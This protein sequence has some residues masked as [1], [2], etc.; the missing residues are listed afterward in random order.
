M[1]VDLEALYKRVK[2]LDELKTDFFANV[3][4]E[5]RTPL[6]LILGPIDRL[7]LH[8]SDIPRGMKADLELARRSARVLQKQVNDLLDVSKLEAGKVGLTYTYADVAERV[9]HTR[10]QFE[11]L[12][13]GRSL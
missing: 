9:R 6:T 2:E 8:E 4:H 12:A 5:L 13:S 1:C 3:N 10:S 11:G 7:L